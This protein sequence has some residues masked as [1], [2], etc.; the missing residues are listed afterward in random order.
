M[1]TINFNYR[2]KKYTI[3][4]LPCGDIARVNRNGYACCF[5]FDKTTKIKGFLSL[6]DFWELMLFFG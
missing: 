4:F 5:R 1:G 6:L 3:D 2:G